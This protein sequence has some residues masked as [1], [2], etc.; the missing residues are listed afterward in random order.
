MLQL[1]NILLINYALNN[2][3][4]FKMILSSFSCKIT[5]TTLKCWFSFFSQ[6]PEMQ[7]LKLSRITNTIAMSLEILMILVLKE[8]L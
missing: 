8:I 1:I 4:N 7:V 3:Y 5:F 6:P 2:S